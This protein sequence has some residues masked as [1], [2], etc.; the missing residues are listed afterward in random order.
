MEY[1]LPETEEA[2]S[3]GEDGGLPPALCEGRGLLLLSGDTC[4]AQTI[5]KETTVTL[6][7]SHGGDFASPGGRK[8]LRPLLPGSWEMGQVSASC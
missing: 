4:A 3:G 2:S 8:P 7:L 6:P 1:L 5:C